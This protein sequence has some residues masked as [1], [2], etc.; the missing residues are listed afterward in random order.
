VVIEEGDPY[1]VEAIRAASIP[2][3]GKA[4]MYRFGELDVARVRRILNNDLSPEPTKP[5]GK[6]PQ[7]CDACQYRIV[8]EALRKKD[9]IVAGDI[10]CY[11]LGVLQPFEAIDSCV[12][13][14]ASL[15]VGLGLRHVLPPDQARRVVS[16]IGDSTFVHSGISGLVEMVY[17]PPPNG[18]VLIILDNAT[19]AMTGHQEHPGTGRTLAHEPTGKVVIEDLARSLG[20]RRVHVIEPHVGS[21]EFDRLLTDCLESN[22]LAVIIARRPCILIAKQLKQYEAE[23]CECNTATAPAS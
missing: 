1:L 5:P 17:N 20:I 19:T 23:Q 16:V 18:H 12:C 3:E 21:D 13:M 10:G 22:E 11:T 6:P 8:F 9:C 7:L 15:G 4:D 2:V 14:G